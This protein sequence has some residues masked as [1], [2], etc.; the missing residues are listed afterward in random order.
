MEKAI[1][2]TRGRVELPKAVRDAM[3]LKP[4]DEIEFI[5]GEDGEFSIRRIANAE[6]LPPFGPVDTVP[7]VGDL[8]MQEPEAL[9]MVMVVDD[10]AVVRKV[11]QRLL[12]RQ[13]WAC[14]QAADG[15]DAL[16]QLQRLTPHV[17]L[18]DIEMPR[19]DGL[20]F[21]S[22]VRR[23][24]NLRHIP[25]VIISSFADE[26]YRERARNLG[27]NVYLNKPYD[28]RELLTHVRRFVTAAY[29]GAVHA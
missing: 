2:S 7:F 16:A 25:I 15:V 12:E 4:G 9:P 17:L 26:D 13:G 3:G 21:T 8:V 6:L 20:S 5:P 24:P 28:E 14:I 18:V 1:V 11:A 10:S 22:T 27:V 19:M 23:M 29:K